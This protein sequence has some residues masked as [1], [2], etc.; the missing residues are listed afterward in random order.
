[1]ESPSELPPLFPSSGKGSVRLNHMRGPA[2][3]AS[4]SLLPLPALPLEGSR[5][6]GPTL[7]LTRRRGLRSPIHS[8]GRSPPLFPSP[9]FFFSFSEEQR[10][11]LLNTGGCAI[12]PPELPSSFPLFPFLPFERSFKA[13]NIVEMMLGLH[14]R[15]SVSLSLSFFSDM[16]CS[17]KSSLMEDV[18][19]DPSSFFFF[20]SFQ[21][22]KM[23]E[24]GIYHY[25]HQFEFFLL[26]SFPSSLSPLFFFPLRYGPQSR[27]VN[28]GLPAWRYDPDLSPLGL[29]P[30]FFF[31]WSWTRAQSFLLFTYDGDPTWRR[32]AETSFSFPFSSEGYF[33]G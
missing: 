12:H 21:E 17:L 23:I 31:P 8:G 5:S 4:A 11:R 19:A 30:F 24:N 13:S 9:P 7:R 18:G 6:H 26:F 15:G 33:Q 1:M 2:P 32:T 14:Q 10:E 3:E 20:F 16:E 25:T 22:R 28:R 27:T 29:F